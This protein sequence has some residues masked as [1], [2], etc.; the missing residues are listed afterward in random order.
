MMRTKKKGVIGLTVFVAFMALFTFSFGAEF[1]GYKWGTDLLNMNSNLISEYLAQRLSH[2]GRMT[3]PVWTVGN[4][5]RGP[6]AYA[7]LFYGKKPQIVYSDEVYG[8]MAFVIFVFSYTG[9]KRIQELGHPPDLR[10]Y[11]LSRID[12]Y[13]QGDLYDYICQ[14]VQKEFGKPFKSGSERGIKFKGWEKGQKDLANVVAR[15][16]GKDTSLSYYG[17]GYVEK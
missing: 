13:W 7:D 5:F 1:Q 12:I 16:D 10:D 14:C 11:V 6:S 15:Y 17:P 9:G 4:P 3:E 2:Q 8:R